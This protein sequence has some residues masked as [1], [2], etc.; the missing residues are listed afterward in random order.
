MLGD[1]WEWDAGAGARS[2]RAH[3]RRARV[4]D[5][6]VDPTAE[7][8]AT[9]HNAR[10]RPCPGESRQVLRTVGRSVDSKLLVLNVL[11]MDGIAS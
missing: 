5:N 8:L 9:W 10:Q 2:S 1:T 11:P 3:V 6:I 4:G 7:L